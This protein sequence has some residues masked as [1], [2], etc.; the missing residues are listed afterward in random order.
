MEEKLSEHEI[1]KYVTQH[2]PDPRLHAMALD[3]QIMLDGL[4]A[5][6]QKF[7]KILNKHRLGIYEVRDGAGIEL[8][9]E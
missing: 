8:P 6:N 2:I 5:E 1:F 3:L 4:D 7:R 9:E